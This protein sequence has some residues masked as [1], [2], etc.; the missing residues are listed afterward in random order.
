LNLLPAKYFQG[1]PQILDFNLALFQSSKVKAF[2]VSRFKLSKEL[3]T[4]QADR[5][6]K[7]KPDK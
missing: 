5:T 2:I 7:I 3:Q 4:G 6:G 1:C